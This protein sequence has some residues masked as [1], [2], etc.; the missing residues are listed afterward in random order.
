MTRAA[1][2]AA[3][4]CCQRAEPHVVEHHVRV[5]SN[6]SASTPENYQRHCARFRK[7]TIQLSHQDVSSLALHQRCA[8]TSRHKP[9]TDVGIMS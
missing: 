7:R 2:A 3:K 4:T 8:R 6:R 1:I 9:G 5:R